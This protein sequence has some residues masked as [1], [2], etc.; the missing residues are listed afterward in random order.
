[1]FNE[2]NLTQPNYCNHE[3]SNT[4]GICD[5][6]IGKTEIYFLP[7]YKNGERVDSLLVNEVVVEK[8]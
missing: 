8:L 5:A 7:V 6:C 4:S 3:T 2:N 1:M